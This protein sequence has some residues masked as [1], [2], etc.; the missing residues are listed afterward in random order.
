MKE[1]ETAQRQYLLAF[2]KAHR[3]RQ[4]SV[5]ELSEALCAE[6]PISVSAV[7]RNIGKMVKDGSVQRFSAN[8]SRSF[9]YQYFDEHECDGHLH[10]KCGECGRIVHMEE[11]S[12]NLL[13]SS[14]LTGNAFHVDRKKSVLVGSCDDC[15][16]VNPDEEKE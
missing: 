5:K 10:L 12:A 13:L 4:Y 11:K 2:L 7:Y 8:G 3:D 15:V 9:L 1:Y 16:A 14:V 6:H